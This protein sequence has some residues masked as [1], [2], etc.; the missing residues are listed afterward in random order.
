MET[1]LSSTALSQQQPLGHSADD[2]M[3]AEPIPA[4]DVAVLAA[5]IRIDDQHLRL[6]PA[7]AEGPVE[8]L[9]PQSGVHPAVERPGPHS[10]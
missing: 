5:L 3:H 1:K 8:G 4:V 2:F 7:E 9:D 6:Q 10:A